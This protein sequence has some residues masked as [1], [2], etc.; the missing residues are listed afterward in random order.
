MLFTKEKM[1]PAQS[2]FSSQCSRDELESEQRSWS[3][4]TDREWREL[5]DD[6][7]QS[8][9]SGGMAPL[10][11]ALA[12]PP[13]CASPSNSITSGHQQQQVEPQP[14]SLPP[15]P[16]S[17]RLPGELNGS[18]FDFPLSIDGSA[19]LPRTPTTMVSQLTDNVTELIRVHQSLSFEDKVK[20]YP[21]FLSEAMI[22]HNVFTRKSRSE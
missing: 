17:N 22:L 16:V 4:L 18:S 15:V 1:L 3:V 11:G 10:A 12:T 20:L 14:C 8:I 2:S 19:L 13:Y 21:E 7:G 9:R 5:L 6:Q